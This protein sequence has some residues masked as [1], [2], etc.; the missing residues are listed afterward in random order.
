MQ[1]K[2]PQ[3]RSHDCTH[4]VLYEG[5]RVL[6]VHKKDTQRCQEEADEKFQVKPGSERC[7]QASAPSYRAGVEIMPDLAVVLA[8]ASGVGRANRGCL[9]C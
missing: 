5:A 2:L 6:L 8:L 7:P 3:P 1:L 4:L 9:A